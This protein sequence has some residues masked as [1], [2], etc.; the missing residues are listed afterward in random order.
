MPM[1]LED[2]TAAGPHLA[3]RPAVAVEL[4]WALSGVQRP[5]QARDSLQQFYRGEPQLR[6]RVEELWSPDERLSY[7][8]YPELSIA[9]HTGGVLFSAD[10]SDLLDHLGDLFKQTPAELPLTAEIPA[11]RDQILVRLGVLRSSA[12]RRGIYLELISEIWEALRPDW[13][14]HGR[15]TVQAD[16]AGRQAEL[17]QAAN[18]RDIMPETCQ[19]M[20]RIDEMVAALGAEGE[21]VIVPTYFTLKGKMVVD[22]PGTLMVAVPASDAAA[23]RARSEL[24]AR[25]LKAISD[26]TRL[27]I[28]EGLSHKDM[29]VTEIAQRYALAQPTVSNHIKLLREA[30]LVTASRDGRSRRLTVRPDIVDDIVREINSLLGRGSSAPAT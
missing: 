28:L 6:R 7:P 27:A 5:S 16:V 30:G 20:E 8:G 23:S 1:F 29:T 10:G 22:L 4:D 18:W 25:R 13:E 9:A 3:V 19:T 2:E 14:Q 21:L 11:D 24:L 12:K 15:T 17:S 26:P